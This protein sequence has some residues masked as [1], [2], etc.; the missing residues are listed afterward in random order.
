MVL[1]SECNKLNRSDKELS[2]SVADS[3]GAATSVKLFDNSVTNTT[4]VITAYTNFTITTGLYTNV[5]TNIL[6]TVQTTIYTNIMSQAAATVSTTT[7]TVSVLLAE[8]VPNNST[9]VFFPVT[10]LYAFKGVT[11][12]NDAVC[13][14][15][16]TYAPLK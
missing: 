6:G 11:V 14:I 1:I 5:F 9:T 13:T 2:I 7:N 3:S 8:T 4:Q 16:I 12:T 15:T 10:P